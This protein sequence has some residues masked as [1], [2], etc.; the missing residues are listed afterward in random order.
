MLTVRKITQD[1]ALLLALPT[2][3]LLA[4]AA[5]TPA[6][7]YARAKAPAHVTVDPPASVIY[8]GVPVTF[9]GAVSPAR[10]G[11]RVVLQRMRPDGHWVWLARGYETDGGHYAITHLFVVPSR[12]VPATLRVKLP[13]NRLTLK[14]FSADFQVTILRRPHLRRHHRV[15]VEERRKHHHQ[16]VEERRRRRRLL[17]E[18]RRRH[19]QQVVEERR[20]HHQQLV[21]ERRR[22]RQLE[23]EERRKHH[24][25]L[26][27]ER[28]KHHQQV[29]EERRKH[30]QQVVEERRRRRQEK[31]KLRSAHALRRHRS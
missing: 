26:V 24:Q 21:E 31:R 9:T 7:S 27:E 3:A 4:L 28:R 12:R 13:S 8:V 19:H 16:L 20:K 15:V 11:R 18:E 1:R 6:A 29:V 23:L 10:V 17:Q 22:R 14:A 25:Q 2:A 5:L 30:H